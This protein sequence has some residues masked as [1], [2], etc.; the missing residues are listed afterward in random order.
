MAQNAI[1]LLQIDE[2][3][4][5]GN[6]IRIAHDYMEHDEIRFRN[7]VGVSC[8]SAFAMRATVRAELEKHPERFD[9]PE[10]GTGSPSLSQMSLAVIARL[11]TEELICFSNCIKAT[12]ACHEEWEFHTHVAVT[13]EFAEVFKTAL[14]ME[15]AKRSGRPVS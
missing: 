5:L 14:D 6:C 13:R 8:S 1:N 7:Q 11:S 10:P 12:L 4:C 15:L 3:I 2:L 9:A